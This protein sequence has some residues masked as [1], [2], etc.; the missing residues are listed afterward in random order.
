MF[1][2]DTANLLLI[3]DSCQK[4][5]KF[6]ATIAD[7]DVFFEDNK[8]FDAVLMNFVI[9]GES[10]NRLSNEFKTATPHIHWNKIKALRNLVAH[11]YL[12]VDAEEI[13]QIIQNQ[14]PVLLTDI[15]LLLD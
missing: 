3:V 1:E 10:V 8:T 5:Q 14:I 15:T 2:K 12:G 6:V 13:W 7:A 11:D 4:I 9:I